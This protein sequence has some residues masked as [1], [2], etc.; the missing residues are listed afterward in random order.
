VNARYLELGIRA[1]AALLLIVGVA[2]ID[3]RLG[4]VAL[5]AALFVSTVDFDR[6]RRA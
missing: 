3:P 4:L 1:V 2:L 5:G 6:R